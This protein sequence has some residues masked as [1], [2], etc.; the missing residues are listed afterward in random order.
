MTPAIAAYLRDLDRKDAA[1]AACAVA[2]RVAA[3]RVAALR[4]KAVKA[5]KAGGL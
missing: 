4:A 2:A 3:E 1:V 5:A